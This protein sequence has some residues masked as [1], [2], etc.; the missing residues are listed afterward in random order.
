MNTGK[1]PVQLKQLSFFYIN[2]GNE[3]FAILGS[4]NNSSVLLQMLLKSSI[5]IQYY[6]QFMLQYLI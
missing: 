5:S 2:I 1:Q 6:V 3:T 4:V